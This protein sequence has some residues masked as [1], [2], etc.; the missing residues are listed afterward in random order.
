V[1]IYLFGY[2]SDDFLGRVVVTPDERTVAHL[3]NQLVAWGL[4]PERSGT[5][6]VRNEVGK[7]LDPA[8]T[9]AQAGLGAGDIFTVERG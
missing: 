9:I 7:I 4:A 8:S 3:A 5:L 6:T 2:A 1:R